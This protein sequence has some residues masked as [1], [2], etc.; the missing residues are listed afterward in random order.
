MRQ[1]ELVRITPAFAR[2]AAHHRWYSTQRWR[3][4]AKRQLQEHPLC[5]MHLQ[6]GQVMPASVADH[7]IPHRGDVQQF[8]SGALQSLC[9]ACHNSAKR[10]EEQDGFRSDVGPDGWPLDPRHPAH[11]CPLSR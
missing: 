4:K 3:R 1:P 2:R 9:D 11:S 5:A 8:W 7:I 10:L 6:R